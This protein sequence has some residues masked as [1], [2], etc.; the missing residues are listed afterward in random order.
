MAF[1][2]HFFRFQGKFL[3]LEFFIWHTLK[4]Q[5]KTRHLEK[6]PA[7]KNHFNSSYDFL[8]LFLPKTSI[9]GRFCSE[10]SEIDFFLQQIDN[11]IS[12]GGL[13]TIFITNPKIFFF[14]NFCL[15]SV[16]RPPF[17]I[18]LVSSTG[19]HFFHLKHAGSLKKKFPEDSALHRA[20]VK[21]KRHSVTDAGVMFSA[22]VLRT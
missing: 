21:D 5:I 14:Q 18:L 13:I 4:Q 3:S 12:Y 22:H 20:D 11:V 17:P 2:G 10:K 15:N 1:L 19:V 16:L 8:Y 7:Q 6:I 9:F